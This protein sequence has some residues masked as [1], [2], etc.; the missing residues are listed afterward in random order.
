MTAH[1]AG[2]HRSRVSYVRQGLREGSV[3]AAMADSCSPICHAVVLRRVE[4]DAR[5]AH[6][7]GLRIERALFGTVLLVRN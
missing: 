4:P 6:F 1:V 7:Y 3:I 2:R 5:M